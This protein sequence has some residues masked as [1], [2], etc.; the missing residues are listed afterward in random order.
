VGLFSVSAG[1]SVVGCAH[2]RS[3]DH[4]S[5]SYRPNSAMRLL[6]SLSPLLVLSLRHIAVTTVAT[7]TKD[8]T[9]TG[10]IYDELLQPAHTTCLRDLPA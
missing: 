3:V 7:N 6:V 8:H 5:P 2:L 4:T 9:A 10:A 1:A